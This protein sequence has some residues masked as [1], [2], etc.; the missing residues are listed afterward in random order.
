MRKKTIQSTFYE[1]DAFTALSK[2]DQDLIKKAQSAAK[3]AYAPYSNLQ[4]GAAV[5]LGNNNFVTGSN[6]ENVAFPSGLC[7]ERVAL[8][9]AKSIFPELAVQSIAIT[10]RRNGSVAA[11]LP[12]PCGACL[13]V[14]AEYERR[15]KGSIRILCHS[16]QKIILGEGVSHFMPLGFRANI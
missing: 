10:A 11:L 5:L 9:Y 7:A 16:P 1:Y 2:Q 3:N 13:Q 14:L 8:Y 15:Q 6:Q 4:M 12:I